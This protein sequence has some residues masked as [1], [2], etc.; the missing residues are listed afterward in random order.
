MQNKIQNLAI[1]IA[2]KDRHNQLQKL[3]ESIYESTRLPNKIVIVYSGR[4]IKPVSN[5]FQ[6]KL[7]LAII[8]S[9]LASQMFQKS[10]GIRTLGNSHQW[11]FFLDDDVVLESD[12]IERLFIEYL[13]NPIFEDYAGFGLSILNRSTR[14]INSITLGILK[15]FN[16]YSNIPGTVTKSGHA[17]SYL[18]H[19]VDVEVQWLNGISVWKSNVLSQYPVILDKNVYS[20]YEDVNFSYK[21]S[22][23]HKLLFATKVKVI[24][25]KT[26]GC[27]PLTINQFVYGGYF[28]YKFVFANI[29]LSKWQL[30]AAQLIRGVDFTF[31]PNKSSR[32]IDR[33]QASLGLWVNLLV[34]V[35]KNKNIHD[36]P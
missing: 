25:Q 22:K 27:A 4:D 11:V 24:N 23:T 36:L 21:V 16:M 29:E 9:E 32:I 2:T 7:D 12:T 20:A 8:H 5:L 14:A 10:I 15:F 13:S 18:D 30:L 35:L 31:R 3:L 1:L 28:R 6:D 34:L 19:P 17:Q 33:L 26:E